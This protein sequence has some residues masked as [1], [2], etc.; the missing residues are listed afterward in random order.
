MTEQEE[1]KAKLICNRIAKIEFFL[2]SAFKD[3][4]SWLDNLTERLLEYLTI[5]SKPT[6]FLPEN[7]DYMIA[8]RTNPKN[9]FSL[10][11]WL[12]R[13]VNEGIISVDY[14]YPEQIK[15]D[16]NKTVPLEY[17]EKVFPKE[18]NKTCLKT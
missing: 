18:R 1:N 9:F 14:S 8:G 11:T 3:K 10:Y 5:G 7:I 16:V 4:E 17:Q 15:K 6:F 2:E 12:I 13:L